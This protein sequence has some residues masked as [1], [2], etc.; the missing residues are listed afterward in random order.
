MEPAQSES[1]V[2]SGAEGVV[3]PPLLLKPAQLAE[4]LASTPTHWV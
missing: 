3:P 4:P 2:H 1:V